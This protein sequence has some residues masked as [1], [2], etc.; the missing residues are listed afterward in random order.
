MTPAN[1][2]KMFFIES[3]VI[4]GRPL[5]ITLPL[6]IVFILFAVTAS[7]LD[8]MEFLAQ[9]PILPVLLFALAIWGLVTPAYYLGGKKVLGSSL[10]ETLRDDSML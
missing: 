10:A 6:T 4:A 8:P 2:R 7:Y 5:L 3:L 9:A 1:I